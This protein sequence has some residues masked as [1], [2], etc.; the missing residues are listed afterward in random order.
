MLIDQW[1]I[2][3]LFALL[4]FFSGI[5]AS[6]IGFAA[7]PLIV[8]LLVVGYGFKIHFAI[9][10]SLLVDCANAAIMTGF[11]LAK[12]TIFVKVG[13]SLTLL[14]CIFVLPGVYLSGAFLADNQNILKGNLAVLTFI[15]G[16]LFLLKGRK[17]GNG[18]RTKISEETATNS[19]LRE[20]HHPRTWLL[21]PGVAGTGLLTGL[22]GVGGGM[23]YA[24]LLIASR[25]FGV[26][27]AAST[28]MLI[29]TLSALFAATTF[30]LKEDSIQASVASTTP[31]VF[32]LIGLSAVGTF[33][34]A[35]IAYSV[36]EKKIYYLVGAIVMLASVA[37]KIIGSLV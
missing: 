36:S 23:N 3:A 24:L 10:L 11:G 25:S 9:A 33:V 28:G 34:G 8:P 22:I 35:K 12:K 4:S 15:I 2:A 37:A 18:S 32:F 26:R 17:Y 30:C 1:P 16:V 14:A 19:F 31:L 29:T 6:A 5:A 21:Y 27:Q 7:W 20:A 13:L